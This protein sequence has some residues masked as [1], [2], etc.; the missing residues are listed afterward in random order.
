MADLFAGA[1]DTRKGH[2]IPLHSCD[3]SHAPTQL[4]DDELLRERGNWLAQEYY[5]VPLNRPGFTVIGGQRAVYVGHEAPLFW[6][7]RPSG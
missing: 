1:S 2:R 7:G 4:S 3:S 6:D 5:P